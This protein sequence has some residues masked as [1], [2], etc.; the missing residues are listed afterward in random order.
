[1][2]INSVQP[3][4]NETYMNHI[5]WSGFKDIDVESQY[6]HY[7][8]EV[9]EKLSTCFSFLGIMYC[10][11][12]ILTIIIWDFRN[13]PMVILTVV[14]IS[15]LIFVGIY[16]SS[17]ITE[18][19]DKCNKY[20][21]VGI[22][23]AITVQIYTC[24]DI[25]SNSHNSLCWSLVLSFILFGCLALT[26]KLRILICFMVLIPDLFFIVDYTGADDRLNGAIALKVSHIF[27]F[28]TLFFRL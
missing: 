14:C 24:D 20:I 4:S 10:L 28:F 15:L 16:L 22:V 21:I 2:V 9:L 26:F 12:Q 3:I 11:S 23:A 19:Q 25:Y 1:M 18:I 17:M 8:T 6:S 27:F 7:R 5:T 13:P